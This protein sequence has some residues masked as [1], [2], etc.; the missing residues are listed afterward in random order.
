M[1]IILAHNYPIGFATGGE[2][3]VFED[4]AEI[5]K[6]HGHEVFKLYCSNSEATNSSLIGK[7]KAFLDA[8]WS[9]KGYGRMAQ[10][11]EQF[12]PDI[13]HVHNFFLI[14]SPSIFKAACDY[15]VPSV[16]T[17]HNYR[18]VSPCSQLLRNGKI[19]E[20]CV[21]R[22]PWRILLFRCYKN[23]FWA[24]L[25]RYRIYYLSR[26]FHNWERYID[27][28]IALTDFGKSKLVQSGME[29]RKISIVPNC[30]IDALKEAPLS[31]PGKYA[32]FIGRLSQEKGLEGLLEA[33][34]EIDYPLIVIGEG[35]L[36][37]RME[38][39]APDNV[40]FAGPQN[41][42]AIVEFLKGSSFVVM[43][44]ICYEGLPLVAVEAMAIGRAIAASGHGALASVIEDNVTGLHFKPGDIKDMRK[45]IGRLI[46]EKQSTQKMGENA[47]KR[48]LSLYTPEKHYEALMKTYKKAICGKATQS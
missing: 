34:Q 31:P 16:V 4:E 19:C 48:Y 18:M 11:I 17:L 30:A 39:I 27:A 42:E 12:R 32:L 21:G 22:N 1:K 23:S 8:P 10:A 36:R 26:K 47:R 45:I 14:Y 5:L 24:S 2:G 13:V 25:L 38:S 7:A 6:A 15:K 43:P 35:E 41:G 9:K 3:H 29:A 20:L 37:T 40:K 33:W 44:S 46:S 28:F